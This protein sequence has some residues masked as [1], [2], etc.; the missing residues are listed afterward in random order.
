[1]KIETDETKL[2][3]FIVQAAHLDGIIEG[4]KHTLLLPNISNDFKASTETY[5]E[6]CL[7][8]QSEVNQEI[9]A[10]RQKL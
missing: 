4:C 10:L 5:L 3:R 9:N 6:F 8:K 1:M 2:K 7:K